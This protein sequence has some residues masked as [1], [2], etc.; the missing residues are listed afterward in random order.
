MDKVLRKSSVERDVAGIS[1]KCEHCGSMYTYVLNKRGDASYNVGDVYRR[2][3]CLECGGRFS[4]WEVGKSQYEVIQE[5]LRVRT[6]GLKL[7]NQ[8][9]AGELLDRFRNLGIIDRPDSVAEKW[10][11]PLF[12]EGMQYGALV[13]LNQILSFKREEVT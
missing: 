6:R 9:K 2:R 7:F 11:D 3:E 5:N 10:N 13:A 4:T 12:V 8:L 1:P